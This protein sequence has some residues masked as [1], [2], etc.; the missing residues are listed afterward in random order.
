MINKS[1]SQL[2]H[3]NNPLNPVHMVRF[4]LIKTGVL[5]MAIIGLY[6]IQCKFLHG[7]ILTRTLNATQP[8]SFDEQIA[9]AI[10]PREQPCKSDTNGFKSVRLSTCKRLGKFKVRKKTDQGHY[11]KIWLVEFFLNYTK[12]ALKTCV[13]CLCLCL[14][15]GFKSESK[16][17]ANVTFLG[18]WYVFQW[19]RLP[20][21]LQESF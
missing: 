8:V 12:L 20:F 14:S 10:A 16:K 19:Q 5:L 15:F 2:H 21:F 11:K 7:A 3:V 1:Q 9:V 4:F 6:G 17:M 13:F 18:D